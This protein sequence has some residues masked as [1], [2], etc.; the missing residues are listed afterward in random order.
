MTN[1]EKYEEAIT[2]LRFVYNDLITI[3]PLHSQNMRLALICE[4]VLT[5][6][7]NARFHK[8]E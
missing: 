4:K 2:V 3:N 5:K 8:E 1:E 7:N 6:I